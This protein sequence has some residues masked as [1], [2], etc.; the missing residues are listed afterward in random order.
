MAMECQ[1]YKCFHY[2][3]L[4]LFN[5]NSNRPKCSSCC[6]YSWLLNSGNT[7]HNH[8]TSRPTGKFQFASNGLC[9]FISSMYK[10]HHWTSYQLCLDVWRWKQFL[11]NRCFKHLFFS[12]KLCHHV[13]HYECSGLSKFSDQK[14]SDL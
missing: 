11:S 7:K 4:K 1:W 10:Y 12:G 3:R 9:G 14:F 13:E 2:A 5:P 8:C 6:I